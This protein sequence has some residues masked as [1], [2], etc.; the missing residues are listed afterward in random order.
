VQ[1]WTVRQAVCPQKNTAYMHFKNFAMFDTQGGW[2]LTPSY[3]QVAALVYHYKTIALSLA[4]TH[5]IPLGKLKP[6]ALLRLAEAFGVLP[7][8]QKILLDQ[9][10]SH[11]ARAK[12]VIEQAD[13]EC[14]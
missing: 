10:A 1:L 5:D 12:T 2:R 14:V 7:G 13:V 8:T 6:K 11:M 4:G 9:L 3:D